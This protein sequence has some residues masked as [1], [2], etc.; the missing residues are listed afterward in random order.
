MIG[1]SSHRVD[2]PAGAP[3]LVA[4]RVR[5][6]RGNALGRLV[7]LL[8]QYSLGI[9]VNLYSTLPAADRGKS[10]LA[11]LAAAIGNGPLLLAIHAV[12]GTVL[13]LTG[14]AATVR[15]LRLGARPLIALCGG[16]LL[17]TIVAW[18]AGTEFVGHQKNGASLTM[19]LAAA[20]AMLCYALVIFVLGLRSSQHGAAFQPNENAA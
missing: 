5:G 1:A 15:A 9:S 2:S 20:V 7:M 4:L 14:T 16:A 8:I 18:L 3:R 19:A 10:F 12:L 17:A 6:L 13:L 11:A